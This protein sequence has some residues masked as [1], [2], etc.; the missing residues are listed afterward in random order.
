MKRTKDIQID[1]REEEANNLLKAELKN[2]IN[3]ISYTKN[4]KQHGD[5]DKQD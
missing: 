5:K 4:R 2:Y 1:K 3:I